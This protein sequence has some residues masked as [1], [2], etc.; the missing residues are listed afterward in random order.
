ML[1]IM[2]RPRAGDWLH[3]EAASWR[4]QG[5]DI[6]VSLLEDGEILELG[7]S[8]EAECCAAAG[9]RFVR[10]PVP[11]RGVPASETSV[12]EL[13][14]SLVGELTA[15][16]GVGIHCRIGVGRSASLAACI[17]MVLG[18]PAE[19]VWLVIEQS[20]GV[21]VPDTQ[22]QRAWVSQWFR[23]YQGLGKK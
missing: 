9:I 7:L 12:T 16:R 21:S 17:L 14:S 18:L 15:G 1:A 8:Q 2:P 10:F 19:S 23:G 3:D 11:D 20:R 13:V 6:V 5:L 4:R 22:A